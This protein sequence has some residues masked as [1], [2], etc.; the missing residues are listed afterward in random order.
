MSTGESPPP[1][2]RLLRHHRQA[3][4]LTQGELAQQAHLTGRTIGDLERGLTQ[5][6]RPGTVA[7]LAE[8]LA[9]MN[10]ERTAFEA[11]A[12]RP[13]SAA[14]TVAAAEECESPAGTVA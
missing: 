7:L 4:G 9:P 2:A 5:M 10:G 13:N 6:L 11:A 12:L 1:F 14:D 3:A 8:A